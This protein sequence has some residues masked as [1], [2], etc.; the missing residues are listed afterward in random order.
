MRFIRYLAAATLIGA[1]IGCSDLGVMNPNNPDRDRVLKDAEG[2]A[3]TQFQQIISGTLGN[4]AR[5]Q[6]GLLTAAFENASGLANNGLGPRSGLPRQPIDN[7][8]GNAYAAENFA[9]YRILSGVA[10][11]S[12]DLLKR[13]KGSDFSLGAGRTADETRLKAWVHFTYGVSLGYLSLVYDSTAIPRPSDGRVDVPELEGHKAVNAHALAQFDSALV[14]LA[15]T[16]SAASS[17]IPA[18]WLNN[19]TVSAADFARVVR[20]FR[21]RM[22]AGVARTPAERAAVDWDKVIADAT[23]GIQA[24]LQVKMDPASGW[25][26][27]WLGSTLHFRDTNWHQMTNYIIGMADVSGGFDA[28]LAVPRD[29]RVPFT[30]V[31][32]DKR[33]P[34]GA[35]RAAQNRASADDDKPLPAG[36][37]FRN[38]LASKDQST[39]GWRNS[40]YDHYRFRALSDAGRVGS[41]P[42]FTKAEN[43]ML[44]AEGYI[45]KN[46]FAAAAELIDRT[47]TVNGLPALVGA[48]NSATD[49]VPGASQCVPRVP[50]APTFTSTACGTILEAMKWEKRMETAYTTYGAWFFDSRGWGDLPAGTA[51]ELPVPSQELD[52]RLKPIYNLGGVGKPGGAGVSTYGYG[53]GDR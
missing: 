12:A 47:R 4:I 33:F 31:T 19:G 38:R 41:L 53:S 32:P 29:D 5:V 18:G 30:I 45:R 36:Q 23:A 21:A 43:D 51:V 9:D 37:Y 48:I 22:R 8:R 34:Q 13:A 24:D 39:K 40:Q 50:V 14:Y 42:F 28:W 49:P 26:Y 35:T 52:A 20:S 2:L 44:A 17:S 16:G 7:N 15:I 10:R 27:N 46:N 3:A 11:N 1:A 6:T 25:D